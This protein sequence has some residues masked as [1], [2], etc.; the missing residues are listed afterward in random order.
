MS[1]ILYR[2]LSLAVPRL[3]PHRVSSRST[4]RSLRRHAH[5]FAES[6]PILTAKQPLDIFAAFSAAASKIG[7]QQGS[8]GASSAPVIAGAPALAL[9][10]PTD[11]QPDKQLA[12][13]AAA[14]KPN[15]NAVLSRLWRVIKKEAGWLILAGG[16]AVAAAA[17]GLATPGLLATFWDKFDTAAQSKGADLAGPAIKLAALFIGRFILQL[18][19]STTLANSTERVA[20][21]LRVELFEHLLESDIA[22]FDERRTAELVDSLSADVKEVR[23]SLR[24]LIG[25]G[26]PA[27]ARVVGGIASLL[28]VSP[29]LTGVLG[30]MLIPGVAIGNALASRLRSLARKSQE[31]QGKAAAS[32]Q[33]SLQNIRTVRAFTGESTESNKYTTLLD[34]SSAISK[35]MGKEYSFFRGIVSLGIT[36]MA[37]GVLWAGNSLIQNGDMTRGQLGSF[38]VSTM[39]LEQA[40]ETVSRLGA[41][42]QRAQGAATRVADLLAEQPVSNASGGAQWDR[43]IGDVSFDAVHF[44][45][46]TRPHVPVLRGVSLHLPPGKVVAVVGPSGSGKSTL[47]NLLLRYYEPTM[48]QVEQKPN[49]VTAGGA[50]T[51]SPA[52][53]HHH[54]EHQGTPVPSSTESPSSK[55]SGSASD[56]HHNPSV[57][58][59][60]PISSA[61]GMV[62]VDGYPLSLVD[63]HWLR[64]H[65]AFVPQDTALFASTLRDNIRYGN[66]SATDDEIKFAAEQANALGFINSLPKG[67]D[68][69]VGERGVS[70][71]GGQRQ[72]VALAR[73]LLRDPKVLLLDEATSALDADSE[74]AVQDALTRAM[75]GR[76]T[77][78]I[79]HRLS[80]I[81]KADLIYVLSHGRVVES[82]SHAELLQR[83]GMYA[84]LVKRQREGAIGPSTSVDSALDALEAQQLQTSGGSAS[85]ER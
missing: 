37:G 71:S 5:A 15:I 30:A 58:R 43:V 33:E 9:D 52:A 82:G 59:P 84:Q 41:K 75:K 24:S 50:A 80:T 21:G 6:I 27:V 42:T 2:M 73:A 77:M 83:N 53:T 45:Y 56:G 4:I 76:T 31:A 8:S 70:L 25:E 18:V 60:G 20:N 7:E 3:H 62:R 13:V 57:H 46:P 23:D 85:G 17:L 81:A 12:Q 64:K 29:K 26:L 40:L 69:V 72:R 39:A 54:V 35:E 32:A 66:P 10:T 28:Y 19:A 1:V 16:L 49:T 22:F 63:A 68:T 55:V 61:A 78:I 11:E 34:R 14:A 65:V 36:A 38:I 79:A 67:L 44:A 51:S 74:A 48:P 47:A